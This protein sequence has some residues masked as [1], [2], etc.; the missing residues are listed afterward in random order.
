MNK[1]TEELRETPTQKKSE[2]PKKPENVARGKRIIQ[3]MSEQGRSMDWAANQVGVSRDS[4][5]NWRSGRD[6]I[7]PANLVALAK[8]LNTTPRDLE[9]GPPP[10]A[11]AG[12]ASA[13]KRALVNAE[14]VLLLGTYGPDLSEEALSSIADFIRFQY[15][16]ERDKR[17]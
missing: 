8:A 3:L 4:V 2:K 1:E 7:R 6:G 12:K 11:A 13:E 15:M 16:E 10:E 5:G 17:R 14:P 9:F